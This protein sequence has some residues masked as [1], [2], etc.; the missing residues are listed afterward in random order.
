VL[1]RLDKK[2]VTNVTRTKSLF[3]TCAVLAFST[4]P[5]F[6]QDSTNCFLR[7]FKPKTA[8]IPPYEVS[9]KPTAAP[10]VTVIVNT[11]DTLGKVSPYLLGNAVAVWVG[12]NVD[13][14]MM[15]NWVKMLSPNLIRFPGGSWS[16]IYFWNE[17]PGDL[18]DSI[19]DGNTYNYGTGK[20]SKVQFYPQFGP[21]QALTP[22]GYYDLRSKTGAQGLITVNYAYARYG[23]SAYPVEQ[24]AHL[25]ASWV[26]YDAG[27]TKFW[28]VGNEVAG[29]WE[30][31]WLIDTALNQDGQPAVITGTLYAQHFKVFEDSMKAAAAAM[32]DTIYIGAIIIQ[33]DGT[34]NSDIANRNWN[35]EVFSTLG[36]TVDF[37]VWH[38]YYGASIT[39]VSGQVTSA[40]SEVNADMSFMEGDI[41]KKGAAKRPLT[42]TEW[43]TN[44][45][46]SVEISIANGMQAVTVFCEMAVHNVGMSTRWLLSNWDTDGM[47][48]YISPLNPSI[49]LW[50]PRPDFYYLY[51]LRQ[52]LG[53]QMVGSSVTGSS[54]ILAYASTFSSGNVGL[55]VLNVGSTNQ[56]VNVAPRNIGVG[57]R[58][59]TYT[60]TGNNNFALPQ[61]VVVNG[62]SGIGTVWGPNTD[63]QN[64]AAVAYPIGDTIA[65]N[66]PP[67]SVEYVLLDAGKNVM[68]ASDRNITLIPDA[69]ELNQ[70]Y[71]NP[72]NPTT[73]IGYSVPQ[74]GFISLKVYNVL[75]Q[76]VATLFSGMQRPGSYT[77]LFDA[78]RLASGVYFYRLQ[79]GNIQI[80]KKLVV[81]K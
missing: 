9:T 55:V 1:K 45:P 5:I 59:Y 43:N 76:E 49:P 24:A 30:A 71:P 65:F 39:T 2:K 75:G 58:F 29:P 15:A 51:Y 78:G 66:S 63:L 19:P 64:I 44:G 27:R 50:N 20:Y 56:V 37:Y 72:F 46:S 69:Y 81:M 33:F 48:Y 60:L 21:N 38:D 6:A 35:Q 77:A 26:R 74:L 11:A 23:T 14:P 25:A 62:D 3:L 67:N 7:D 18:P 80:T 13:N 32:G 47:F 53:D 4:A 12:Q 52:F 34:N 16:D 8:V 28:E 22:V 40:R 17:D 41:A 61:S 31:G 68:S 10:T 57:N 42:L 73:T 70:N 54:N 79:T 36:D